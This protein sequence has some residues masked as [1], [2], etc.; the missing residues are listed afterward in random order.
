MSFTQIACPT[1]LTNKTDC[2]RA[3][4]SDLA[5]TSGN[6]LEKSSKVAIGVMVPVGVILLVLIAL[7]LT[8]RLRSQRRPRTA[9]Q[10]NSTD[11]SAS[12]QSEVGITKRFEQHFFELASTSVHEKE[13]E[14]AT[15]TAYGG[16]LPG[17]RAIPPLNFEMHP[18][19]HKGTLRQELAGSPTSE[20]V[21]DTNIGNVLDKTKAKR[22]ELEGSP[23]SELSGDTTIERVFN[24]HS[25]GR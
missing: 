4:R 13:A 25:E 10:P 18:A 5:A 1:E 11:R 15:S 12:E 20:L 22:S 3:D 19:M 6:G 24:R 17:L 2:I 21:G 23:T 14:T 9:S 8:K 16:F 7:W